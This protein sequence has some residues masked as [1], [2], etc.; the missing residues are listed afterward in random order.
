MYLSSTGH[1]GVHP[2]RAW[3]TWDAEWDLLL[4]VLEDFDCRHMTLKSM[5]NN[6]GLPQIAWTA[7]KLITKT[8]DHDSEL[9]KTPRRFYY[10][11][12]LPPL[13]TINIKFDSDKFK[14]PTV[15]SHKHQGIH[16]VNPASSIAWAKK[17]RRT[18]TTQGQLWA[19]SFI[20]LRLLMTHS[21]TSHYSHAC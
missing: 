2:H 9:W 20:W 17:Q 6:H 7:T 5:L 14:V 8:T 19:T 21:F 18:T 16:V 1:Q 3:K 4:A 15:T 10:T 12:I 11:R 13:S